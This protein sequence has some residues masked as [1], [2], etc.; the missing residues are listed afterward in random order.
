MKKIFTSA[1]ILFVLC[2]A[3]QPLFS[4]STSNLFTGKD[5]KSKELSI[6]SNRKTGDLQIRF[7]AQ[8]EGEVSIKILNE[9]GI[10]VLEQSNHVTANVNTI[11]LKKAMELHEG[12][13]S[14]QV[15]L[16]NEVAK[17]KFLIWK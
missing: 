5:G 10:L 6:V 11:P 16:N 15:L 14:I 7:T 2:I 17:T 3:V 13:Y 8:K 1:F 4:N 9:S 12:F